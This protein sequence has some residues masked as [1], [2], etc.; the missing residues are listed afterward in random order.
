MFLHQFLWL[1]GHR[2]LLSFLAGEGG[3]P[4]F[5]TGTIMGAQGIPQNRSRTSETSNNITI[6]T[7]KPAQTDTGDDF[8]RFK[9]KYQEFP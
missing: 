1:S 4:L 6:Q 8:K 3:V 5:A 2:P 7:D 9:Y